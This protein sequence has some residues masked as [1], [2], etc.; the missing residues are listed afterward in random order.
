ML[1]AGSGGPDSTALAAATA[2]VAPRIGLR[3][4]FASVDH[5][6]STGSADQAAGAVA[7]AA[8]LGLDPAVVLSAAAPRSE[9]AA[10]EA[11]RATLLAEARTRDAGAVLLAHTLDDQ[12]ET[13]LLRLARGSGARSLAGMAACTG[14]WRRPLLSLRRTELRTAC[15]DLGLSVWDDPSNADPA[16]ARSRVRHEVLPLLEQA[17][18]PGIAPS[19]AR[20]ADLLRADADALDA[21]AADHARREPYLDVAALAELAAA[22]RTRV[23]RSAAIRAGSPATALTAVHVAVLDALVTGWHGQGPLHL[24]GGVTGLRRNGRIVLA[25]S[26][27]ADPGRPPDPNS[28]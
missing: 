7:V 27:A 25:Q 11:R 4:S 15:D 19:L 8:A 10:R 18:G 21:L 12:A 9:G 28:K 2:F 14:I 3:P 22:V 24:P 23:L 20:T 5:S 16:F 1:V 26:A 6:W 13:V 17:L